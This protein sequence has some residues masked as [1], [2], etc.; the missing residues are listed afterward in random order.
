VELTYEKVKSIILTILVVMSVILT[1][2][3]WSFQPNVENFENRTTVQEVTL[4][5]KK[6]IK[7]IVKIDQVIFNIERKYFGTV[8]SE[9]IDNLMNEISSWK[10]NSFNPVPSGEIDDVASIAENHDSV[11]IIYPGEI[12]SELFASIYKLNGKEV[13]SFHFNQIM[14]DFS[15]FDNDY[16]MVYFI[17]H[18][19]QQVYSV[20]VLAASLDHFRNTFFE[21]AKQYD[22][23]FS[24]T[25]G[26]DRT[27]YLPQNE[28]EL[29]NSQYLI[30][31]I[32]TN[33]LKNALFSNPSLVQKNFTST[34]EEYTDGQNLMRENKDSHLITYINPSE[35]EKHDTNTEGLLQKS[36]NFVN[37]HGGYTD[38][39][40]FVGLDK[41]RKNVHFRIYGPEGYPVFG[42]SNPISKIEIEWA[43]T[44]ISS[45]RRSN[46][47]PGLL[48]SNPV[49]T[50]ESGYVALEKIEK[51][52]Q[53]NRNLLQ[54]I[55]IGYKMTMYGK[56]LSLEPSWFCLYNGVWEPVMI[57]AIGGDQVGME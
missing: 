12:P 7:D 30:N 36:I 37:N 16:G 44:E 27:I 28:T 22:Q 23:Y 10:F 39:Y 4:S 8:S 45:Y 17:S 21:R 43:S 50:L 35:V 56:T 2:N 13:P 53:F 48:I 24:F 18:E 34:G 52:D 31:K 33:D 38:N 32:N 6:D 14:L 19:N 26:T 57:N 51:R 1:W 9:E 42:E 46:F 47:Y 25:T 11:Q 15:S 55:K 5:P 40:R 54:D 41:G 49:K 29:V 3:L 20:R